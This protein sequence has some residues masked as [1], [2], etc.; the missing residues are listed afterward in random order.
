VLI[1]KVYS[2]LTGD[3]EAAEDFRFALNGSSGLKIM[4]AASIPRVIVPS[5]TAITGVHFQVDV[6]DVTESE[7][8][9]LA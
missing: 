8:P 5:N 4:S 1:R 2:V 3:L 6:T 7:L 9:L